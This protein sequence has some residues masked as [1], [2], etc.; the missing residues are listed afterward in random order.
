M[1]KLTQHKKN[2]IYYFIILYDIENRGKLIIINNIY[3]RVVVTILKNKL[4]L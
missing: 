4:Y 3:T 1:A 2:T